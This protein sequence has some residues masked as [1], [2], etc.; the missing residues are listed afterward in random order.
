MARIVII[1][2][3]IWICR[4]GYYSKIIIVVIYIIGIGKYILL[5]IDHF[6]II[7]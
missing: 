7:T 1:I 5:A 3:V 4:D 6:V 2:P